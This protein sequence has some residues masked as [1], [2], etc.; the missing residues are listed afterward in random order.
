MERLPYIDEHV[1]TIAAPR[2]RA[3]EALVAVGA[4]LGAAP[5]GEVARLWQL[6]PARATAD[7]GGSPAAGAARPGFAV[8]E[9]SA[10]AR[11]ALAGR[12]R[13]SRYTLV[14]ELDATAPDRT[15]IRA[16]TNAAFPGLL[17][18]VYRALV[19]GSGGHRM[20]VGRLLRRVEARACSA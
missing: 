9:V 11:L 1:R 10:P 17:G 16:R 14:F 8:T 4:G 12:H 19:I 5:P 2:E 15:V 18:R 20:I 3:W 13:F 6:E 7:W